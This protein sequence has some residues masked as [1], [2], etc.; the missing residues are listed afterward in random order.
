[1]SV[2]SVDDD[3]VGLSPPL[4]GKAQFVVCVGNCPQVLG[5]RVLSTNRGDQYAISS[6]NAGKS[7]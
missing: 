6:V 3:E 5:P 2:H 7:G 4:L 1:M